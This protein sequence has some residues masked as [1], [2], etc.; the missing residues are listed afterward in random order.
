MQNTPTG[1][2]FLCLWRELAH[3]HIYTKT[4]RM[5]FVIRSALWSSGEGGI[6]TPGASQLNGFQDRRNRPL[7]HLSKGQK[8]SIFLKPPN[9]FENIFYTINVNTLLTPYHTAY[10]GNL[11]VPKNFS[12]IFIRSGHHGT[13]TAKYRYSTRHR[14]HR[15]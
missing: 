13:R 3:R 7:C 1:G 9:I 6:R 2:L 14:H 10:Y 12:D 8:Y 11:C 5:T 15:R 4:E